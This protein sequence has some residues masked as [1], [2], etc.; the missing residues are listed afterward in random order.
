MTTSGCDRRWSTVAGA[1]VSASIQG[2][3][4]EL[5]GISQPYVVQLGAGDFR[6]IPLPPW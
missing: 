2:R 4:S 5:Y 6:R 3:S 1:Y